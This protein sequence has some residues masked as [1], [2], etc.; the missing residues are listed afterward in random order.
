MSGG[1]EL[2]DRAVGCLRGAL[3]QI[4]P[5]DLDR[6]TGCHGWAVRDLLAHLDDG[7]DAFTEAAGGQVRRVGGSS[8]GPEPVVVATKAGL[9][10]GTWAALA[11]ESPP[12]VRVGQLPTGREVLLTAAAVELTV[13]SWDLGCAVEPTTGIPPALAEDLLPAAAVLLD[14]AGRGPHFAP[15]R[16][17]APGSPPDL[18]LLA[19]TGRA[20]PVTKR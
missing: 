1:L 18:R 5:D 3:A 17:V 19:L 16:W 15:P 20:V 13:H 12:L 11:P 8:S 14:G 2:L 9:L 7:L 4:G 10:L 6:P